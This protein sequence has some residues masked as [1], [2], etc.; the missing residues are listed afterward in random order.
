MIKKK[1][2]KKLKKNPLKN[3]KIFQK[4]P[5]KKKKNLNLKIFFFIFMKKY[6]GKQP[7]WN[8]SFI[9]PNKIRLNRPVSAAAHREKPKKLDTEFENMLFEAKKIHYDFDPLKNCEFS[10]TGGFFYVIL[11]KLH[12]K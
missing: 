7:S 4:N 2:K 1:R 9:I 3:K 8:N 6:K 5:F 11:K 10:Y 12:I